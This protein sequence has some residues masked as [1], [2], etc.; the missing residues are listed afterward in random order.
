MN[1]TRN[2]ILITGGGTGIGRGLAEAFC[3]LGNKV[4]IAGRRQSMLHEVTAANPG[5]AAF[6]V[7][8]TSDQ[9]IHALAEQVTAKFPTLNV[10]IHC[11]GIMK[12][13]DILTQ[14]Q[15]LDV[16][17]ATIS[18]N[19]LGPIRLTAALLP[20]LRK[21][22]HAAIIT[23]S[24]GLAFV[25][26]AATPTYSASKAAVHSY[27][28]SLRYQLRNTAIQVIELIPPYVQT[29]LTGEHQAKD[30]AA[31]PLD[32]FITETMGIL[33]NEPT[34]AEINV[35]RVLPLRFAA[36]HGQAKYDQFFKERN[37]MV[38]KSNRVFAK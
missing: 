20:D 10:V 4:I 26:M 8:M 3:K 35:K 24:S 11:A 21:Q 33:A 25:P 29:H 36:D 14:K 17:D 22:P 18:T 16:V 23:V 13:E 38:T 9:S 30:P 19:V 34:A 7:D 32:E 27:T 5:I 28:Q 31:M 12:A 2:T 15:P 1:M 6:T 37:D